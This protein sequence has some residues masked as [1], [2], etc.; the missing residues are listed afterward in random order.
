LG[1][2]GGRTSTELGPIG[3]VILNIC[4]AYVTSIPPC[5]C[6]KL[7]KCEP[8]TK[9]IAVINTVLNFSHF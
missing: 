4:T 7:C 1:K 9:D 6:L 2:K 5:I 3:E 8:K